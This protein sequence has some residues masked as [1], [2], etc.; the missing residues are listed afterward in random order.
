MLVPLA[1]TLFGKFFQKANPVL[2]CLLQCLLAPPPGSFHGRLVHVKA[3]SWTR[4]LPEMSLLSLILCK[5]PGLQEPPS[6][7]ARLSLAA[8]SCAVMDWAGKVS[9]RA[10]G[11]DGSAETT[12]ALGAPATCGS[13]H[14]PL[15]PCDPCL[16]PAC[17]LLSSS[18]SSGIELGTLGRRWRPPLSC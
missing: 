4:S 11:S 8:F 6:S 16:C 18:S 10:G 12:P 3:T 2:C 7:H 15:W 14:V 1:T 5:L 9:K 17:C 13:P